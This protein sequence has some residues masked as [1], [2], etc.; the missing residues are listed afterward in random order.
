MLDQA[1]AC[2]GESELREIVTGWGLKY[3]AVRVTATRVD[4]IFIP[5]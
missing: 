1:T 5:E 2:K 4:V 3:I